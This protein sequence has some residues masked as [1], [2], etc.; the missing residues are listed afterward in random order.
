LFRKILISCGIMEVAVSTLAAI[1][2]MVINVI[3]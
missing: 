2:T 1:P 3:L